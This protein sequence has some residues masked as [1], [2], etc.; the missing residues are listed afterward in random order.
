MTYTL[1]NGAVATLRASGTERKIKYPPPP[2]ARPPHPPLHIF[3]SIFGSEISVPCFLSRRTQ[4][5]DW[6]LPIHFNSIAG[7]MNSTSEVALRSALG[8]R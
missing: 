4:H 8:S 6:H 3:M 7:M 5:H 1:E 2:L